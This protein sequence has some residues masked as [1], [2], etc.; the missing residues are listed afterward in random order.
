MLCRYGLRG[1]SAKDA[2]PVVLTR[3]KIDGIHLTGMGGCTLWHDVLQVG[4]PLL[5]CS[6]NCSV[7]VCGDK[8]RDLMLACCILLLHCMEIRIKITASKCVGQQYDLI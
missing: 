8:G 2:K 7:P 5:C 6:L 4:V 3:D 1:F